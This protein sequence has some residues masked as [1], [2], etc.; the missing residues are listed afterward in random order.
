MEIEGNKTNQ[1]FY[2][3]FLKIPETEGYNEDLL[4]LSDE[5]NIDVSKLKTPASEIKDMV[6]RVFEVWKLIPKS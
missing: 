2:N 6:Q 3:V 1:A 4:K 5:D